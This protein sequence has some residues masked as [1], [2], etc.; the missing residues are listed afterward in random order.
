MAYRVLHLGKYYPPHLGG[1]E[2]YLQQLVSHQAKV[3]D[4]AAIVTNDLRHTQVEFR[5]GAKITRVASL[6]VIASMPVTPTMTWHI[7]Q[8][9]VDL[10]HLHTPNPGAAL[11]LLMSQHSGKLIITHHAD[12]LGRKHLRR[13][14]DP[15]V[16]KVM[17]Q[18]AAIIVTSKRYLES[19]EELAPFRHKC[20]IIPLGVDDPSSLEAADEAL[21]QQI[22]SLY[23]DRLILAVG[24]LVPYKGFEYL[25]QSMKNVGGTLLLIGRGP[26]QGDMQACIKESC[27]QDKVHMLGH[28][29]DLV[30]YY[31]AAS[32]FVM[33]SIT[34][35]EAFG[36]V[37]ME[38]MAA[39]IPVINTDIPSGVPEV[40]VHGQ[41]GFTVPPQNPEAMAD[42]INLLLDNTVLRQQFGNAA[43]ERV[44]DR[45]S[46]ESM[47]R[48][49][50]DLYETVMGST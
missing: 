46:V 50:M 19:S 25:I 14:S 40:S 45:F 44:R 28:V 23:G 12:T 22:R 48:Q 6:G 16:R 1:M 4:V 7:H 26:S 2:V 36:V 41:T 17:K 29:D 21:S 39:G 5:D 3:M 20:S 37:Q 30:P 15:I 43:R 8:C 33:P 10:I 35:A 38:A 32:M 11:A 31:K 13:L 49:T 27:V 9:K 42:A 34:R 18:S 24:R 47:V